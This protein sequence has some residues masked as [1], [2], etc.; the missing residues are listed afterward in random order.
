MLHKYSPATAIMGFAL[1]LTCI[2]G[3]ISE[4]EANHE[5]QTDPLGRIHDC[6]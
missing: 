5:A 6:W 4:A 3:A 1:L 2:D